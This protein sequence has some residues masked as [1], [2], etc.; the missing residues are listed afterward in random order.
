MK[1]QPAARALAVIIGILLIA[2]GVAAGY[3]LWVNATNSSQPSLLAPILEFVTSTSYQTWMLVAAIIAAIVALLLIFA[4]FKPRKTTHVAYRYG[5][6]TLQLRKLDFA[7]LLTATALSYPGIRGAESTV[8]KRKATVRVD[9]DYIDN[10]VLDRL[11]ADEEK[12]AAALDSP[13]SVSIAQAH[14]KEK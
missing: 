9:A 3:E 12:H 7:R 4:A 10:A 1:A 11:K 13:V 5:D 2:L 8:G 14:G 6:T